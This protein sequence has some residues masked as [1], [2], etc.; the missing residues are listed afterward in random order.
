MYKACKVNK[1]LDNY[2]IKFYFAERKPLDIQI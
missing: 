2:L 1:I